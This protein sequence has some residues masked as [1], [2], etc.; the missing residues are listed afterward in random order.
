MRAMIFCAGLGT[1]LRPLSD[2][3]PKPACPVLNRPLVA[4]NFA[5]L[6]GLGVTEVAVNTHHLA[7]R[8]AAAA[9][10]EA[11]A[12]GLHLKLSREDVLMGHGGGLKA[13]EPW[14]GSGTFLALNGDFLFDLDLAGLLEAHRRSHAAATLAVQKPL[15]GY[16]P[17]H[18][19]PDGRLA[20]LP[21]ETPPPGAVPWHFTGVHVLEP[22]IF[23]GLVSEPSGIFETGYRALLAAGKLVRVH[24]DR[25]VWRDIQT[26][27]SYLT[28]NLDALGGRLD[29]SRFGAL[30]KLVAVD[31]RARVEGDVEE[32][33]VGAGA[34]VPAGASVRRSVVLPGTVLR[35]G[36]ELE[37]AIAAGELR[38]GGK[39]PSP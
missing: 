20:C 25:G 39:V 7:D 24:E 14:L 22:A 9:S 11:R 10:A 5:L 28:T 29:L 21:G 19:H 17:L 8:M 32:S 34:H 6:K 38:I 15:E 16:R 30:G 23:A 27:E 13:V 31:A 33:V 37:N 26:T 36:E 2:L 1:R 12:L 18:A 4:F 3:W 35:E